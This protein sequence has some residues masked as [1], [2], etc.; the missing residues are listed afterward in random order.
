MS[1]LEQYMYAYVGKLLKIDLCV[2]KQNPQTQNRCL[3]KYTI[4]MWSLLN[5]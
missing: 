3:C 5:K 2:C 4:I 1:D